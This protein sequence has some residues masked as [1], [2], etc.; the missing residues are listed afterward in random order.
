MFVVHADHLIRSARQAYEERRLGF[1]RGHVDSQLFYDD[2]SVCAIGAALP[3]M[4]LKEV[5]R[6]KHN[7]FGWIELIR[8][9]YIAVNDHSAMETLAALQTAYDACFANNDTSRVE[10]EAVLRRILLIA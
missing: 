10:S 5:V 6:Q 7:R 1:Q 8:A 9:D 3:S 2:G 4:L